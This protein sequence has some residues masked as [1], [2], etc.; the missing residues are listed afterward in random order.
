MKTRTS[1]LPSITLCAAL[2]A[3]IAVTTQAQTLLYQWNFDNATGTDAT[4]TSALSGGSGT[5]G[6]LIN[7]GTTPGLSSPAGSG[8]SGAAADLG[9]VQPAFGVNSGVAGGLLG[10]LTGVTTFTVSA[11]FKLGANLSGGTLNARIFDISSFI[12]GDGNRLYFALNTGT[13]LQFGVN[14]ASTGP[15]LGSQGPGSGQNGAFSSTLGNG[16]LSG[17]TNNWLFV[18]GSYNTAL[19]GTVNLFVGSQSV[20]AS[21]IGSLTNVGNIAWDNSTDYAYIANRASQGA[22]N[23]NRALPGNIDD[24][25]LYS[26]AGDVAFIQGVQGVPEPGTA[27]L[28]GLG[29]LLAI[30]AFRRRRS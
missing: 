20:S 26:G 24:V 17:M 21:L 27:T 3:A 6:N 10:D 9:L 14:L 12:N 23:G 30:A 15:V 8:L 2:L 1:Q 7:L 18:A 5:G 28:I 22:T 4:W 13:N 19:N 16:T 29:G 25:R 11:W